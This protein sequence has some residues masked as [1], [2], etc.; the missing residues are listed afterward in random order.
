M[1][2]TEDYMDILRQISHSLKRPE[3][4]KLAEKYISKIEDDVQRSYEKDGNV[5]LAAMVYREIQ[6]TEG[7]IDFGL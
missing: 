1:E 5:V 2:L 6:R 7:Q 3:K 4:Q